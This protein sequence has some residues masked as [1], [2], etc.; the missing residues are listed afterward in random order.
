MIKTDLI[1]I[2]PTPFC[3]INCRYCYLPAR[4]S[5]KKISFETIGK[6][7]ERLFASPFVGEEITVVWHAGE[8]L[9]LPISF[10]EKAYAVM[11][12][13][14]TAGIPIV[15]SFQTNATLITA[16]WCEFFK[17]YN[18]QVGVSIDGPQ[19][20]HDANRVD[21]SGKGTFDRALRG[22]RLLQDVDIQPPAIMVVTESA[23]D[24]P[25]EVWKFFTETNIYRVGFNPE[26]SEGF[27][28]DSTLHN[29]QAEAKYG[30]FL[31]R[32]LALSALN[33]TPTRIREFTG[34]LNCLTS[35]DTI[36][37]AQDN[38]PM[39]IL[40]FDCEGNV[41]TFSPE[42]L[43]AKHQPYGDFL[44]GNVYDSSLEEIFNSA[45]FQVINNAIQEGVELCR[46]S[47]EYFAFCGGGSPS[48][49]IA[50]QGTFVTTE[51]NTCRLRVKIP[52][53][54][55]LNQLEQQYQIADRNSV[56]P[57]S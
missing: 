43:T 36:N 30:E 8:P 39:A 45:K 29:S 50:E 57:E 46:Q 31:K 14:N 21:R 49:K 7:F 2:Q 20:T 24:Y 41:S 17:K 44:F 34:I 25:E 11:Q 40:S 4:S 13:H 47:C 26:E 16:E 38:A 52:V 15:M 19:F 9:V 54:L 12:E 53:N 33:T 5:T 10:Y 6:I 51:T 23:L 22:I 28:E 1:I 27:H 55:V 42:L 35:T 48:N 18:A 37:H 56:P 32:I 3:N